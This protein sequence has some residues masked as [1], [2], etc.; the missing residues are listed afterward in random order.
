MAE[1]FYAYMY[2]QGGN[3]EKCV[4]D[5]KQAE[6]VVMDEGIGEWTHKYV[7]YCKNPSKEFEE[8]YSYEREL[9]NWLMTLGEIDMSNKY[10]KRFVDAREATQSKME[11]VR[12]EW[13][14]AKRKE[15]T[16]RYTFFGL[17]G[18]WVLLVLIFVY[19]VW[20]L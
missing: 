3:P 6:T 20:I 8:E 15:K 13:L 17:C 11:G 19:V 1:N 2:G 14:T 18:L 10:F 4:H 9:E 5:E 7:V 12:K 16:W